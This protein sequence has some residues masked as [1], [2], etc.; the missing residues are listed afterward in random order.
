M[1]KR[2]KF[3]YFCEKTLTYREKRAPGFKGIIKSSIMICCVL[4]TIFIIN[5][6]GGNFI[7][8]IINDIIRFQKKNLTFSKNITLLKERA[9]TLQSQLNKLFANYKDLSLM[10]N[11]PGIESEIIQLGTGG[12]AIN[13]KSNAIDDMEF[14]SLNE[15]ENVINKISQ[16]I[17]LQENSYFEILKKYMEDQKL[18]ECIPAIKPMSGTYDIHSF[19][20]RLHPILKYYKMHDGVDIIA[21]DGTPVYASGNG[22]IERVEYEGSYGL[23]IEINHGYGYKS[24]Y[25]HLANSDVAIGENVLRGQ[26]IGSCGHSG[27]T[28]GPHLHYEVKI[29]DIKLDPVKFFIDEVSY[30]ENNNGFLRK[31]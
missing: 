29:N 12:K 11:L 10:V 17:K 18:F 26:K 30:I 25:A 14:S 1:F 27:L 9:D 31:E 3:Y 15:I 22:I 6:I 13:E 7:S 5:F 4:A 19:G 24:L 16:Q 21:S 23:I 20:I 8:N 28:T 2:Q